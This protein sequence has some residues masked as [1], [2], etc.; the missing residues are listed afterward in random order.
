MKNKHS[1]WSWQGNY[2]I[3]WPQTKWVVFGITLLLLILIF[4]FK[5]KIKK[6][7]T[8]N[9]KSI[10]NLYT[11]NY[12]LIYRWIGGIILAMQF[13][14]LFLYISGGY[15]LYWEHFM[16]H[17]CR[18]HIFIIAIFM[19]INKKEMIKYVVY[20]STFGAILAIQFGEISAFA[21]EGTL[22]EEI[23]NKHNIE[24]YDVGVD[25]FFY[26]DFFLLHIFIIVGPI[27]L[28]TGYSWKIQTHK[29]Y[30][31]I[32]FYWAGI[33][34]MWMTNW[35]STYI[36]AQEWHSNNWYIGTNEVNYYYDAL[37]ILSTWPYNLFFITII[38]TAFSHL[39]HLIYILQSNVKFNNWKFSIEKSGIWSEFI[40]SYNKNL[41]KDIFNIKNK[42]H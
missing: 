5:D 42:N 14:K 28:W 17:I 33:L 3:W 26:Y 9:T 12:D 30:R 7:H 18:I 41:F 20:I 37:G 32:L 11:G 39:G 6:S 40:M 1:F 8:N 4:V 36:P 13:L 22:K 21:I 24:F 15:P 25:N 19:I 16:L 38:G 23:F 31:S 27:Y 10:M 35:L 29:F 34:F 2:S